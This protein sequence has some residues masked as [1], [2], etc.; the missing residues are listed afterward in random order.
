[1]QQRGNSDGGLYLI[2][3][4]IGK[5]EFRDSAG[6]EVK[7][8]KAV[9]KPRMFGRLIRKIREAKLPYPPQPLKLGRVNE[10]DHESALVRIGVNANNIVNRISVNSLG[11]SRSGLR[12]SCLF[13][14]I[15]IIAGQNR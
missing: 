10:R 5:T 7:C 4:L 15:R 8:S 2:R 3:N 14:I 12:G 9:G 11:Q 6:R 13:K 1:M